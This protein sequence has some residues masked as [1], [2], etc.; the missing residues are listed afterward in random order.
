MKIFSCQNC[1][2]PLYFENT[3][4][5]VC[6]SQVGYL[7]ETFSLVNLTQAHSGFSLG[8]NNGKF[9]RYCQNAQ[10]DACNWLVDMSSSSTFC[11]ACSLNKTIPS[12][13]IEK[14]LTEWRK[15]EIAKHRLVYALLRFG[16]PVV[17]KD[18]AP[19]EGLAFNFL[20]DTSHGNNNAPV[21]TGHLNGLITINIAEADSVH[22]E[23]MRK[24]MAEPYR[25][26]IGHFR[27]EVG[28]YYWE[29]LI[30]NNFQEEQNFR[31]VFG[32]ERAD[33]GQALEK[34]YAQGAPKN[35]NYNYISAYAASHPWEDWAE[36]WAHYLHLIDMLETAFY[37]GIKI[38]DD[39]GN[40]APIKMEAVFDPYTQPDFEAIIESFL[41]LTFALNSLNRSMG[42]PDIYPFVIPDNVIGKLRYVHQLLHKK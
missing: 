14:N 5:L 11:T 9:Y 34:H 42:Q 25:T 1:R 39:F 22:R 7:E 4:C 13:E 29:R 15:I 35:W 19:D 20:S 17:D 8:T 23:Y 10:Y 16:L 27:H 6:G 28:H 33:Y 24:Q 2:N 26:L 3:V 36:T 37:F 41:P 31:A 30:R 12:L 21:R 38:G 32:D 40:T 18:W